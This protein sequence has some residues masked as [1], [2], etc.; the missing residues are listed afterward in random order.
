MASRSHWALPGG[1]NRSSP[2][3]FLFLAQEEDLFAFLLRVVHHPPPRRYL[4]CGRKTMPSLQLLPGL[5]PPSR[6][7][8]EA[9]AYAWQFFPIV[10]SKKKER[11]RRALTGLITQL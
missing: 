5:L 7:T 10:R 2:R 6:E 1:V 8:W 9:I 3:L 11:T 4:R